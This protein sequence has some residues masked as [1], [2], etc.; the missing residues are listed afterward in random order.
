MR[1]RCQIGLRWIKMAPRVI[2][3]LWHTT[4]WGNKSCAG[5]LSRPRKY[6]RRSVEG[7]FSCL[8]LS[9][10]DRHRHR[11]S[12]A[13]APGRSLLSQ[14]HLQHPPL[15]HGGCL[16]S[17]NISNNNYSERN[18]TNRSNR[19]RV[20]MRSD[21]FHRVGRA[22]YSRVSIPSRPPSPLTCAC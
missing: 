11:H 4:K 6:G 5:P 17:S 10:R 3:A 13:S 2:Y 12:K 15:Y 14:V 8:R 7:D 20:G 22:L 16:L 19:R 18:N 9:H 1:L 21:S